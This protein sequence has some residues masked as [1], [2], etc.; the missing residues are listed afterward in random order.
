M[1]SLLGYLA[2]TGIIRRCCWPSP[3]AAPPRSA[4][5]VISAPTRRR[6]FLVLQGQPEEGEGSGRYRNVRADPAAGGQVVEVGFA[7]R[8]SDV[9]RLLA[10]DLQRKA[11]TVQ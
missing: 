8:L 1:V 3:A 9:E 11:N 2:W 4:D 6:P 7:G 5:I 10:P